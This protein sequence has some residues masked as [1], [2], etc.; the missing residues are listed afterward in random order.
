MLRR[1]RPEVSA[2]DRQVVRRL[3]M[4]AKSISHVEDAVNENLEDNEDLSFQ[5]F[6]FE[7]ET[8]AHTMNDV[9]FKP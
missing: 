1:P 7:H 5:K 4:W 8:P 6:R 9:D 3:Q 2:Y